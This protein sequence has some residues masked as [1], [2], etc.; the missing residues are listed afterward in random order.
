VAR[1]C[2]TASSLGGG[3]AFGLTNALAQLGAMSAPLIAGWLQDRTASFA[4]ACY[5]PAAV[6]GVA[7][8]VVL[9]AFRGGEPS[10]GPAT[11]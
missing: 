5:I 1:R 10:R 4:A 2:A 6:L 9:V 11:A 7:A 8:V 3:A